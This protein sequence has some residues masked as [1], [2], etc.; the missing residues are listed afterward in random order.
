MCAVKIDTS[1]SIYNYSCGKILLDFV[2]DFGYHGGLLRMVLQ[3]R[4]LKF[5]R[6]E[7]VKGTDT[8]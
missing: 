4:H 7:V 1:L 6:E 2:L 5:S 3:V 8:R